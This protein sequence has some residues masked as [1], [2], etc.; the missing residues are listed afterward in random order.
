MKEKPVAPK[1]SVAALS[2]FLRAARITEEMNTSAKTEDEKGSVFPTKLALTVPKKD[3]KESADMLSPMEGGK[4]G[5]RDVLK[6][7]DFESR[8]NELALRLGGM[9]LNTNP[10]PMNGNQEETIRPMEGVLE[11]DFVD[12]AE[13]YLYG[14]FGSSDNV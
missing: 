14:G 1:G 5:G 2:A 13:D 11:D 7:F 6:L 10:R 8:K 12:D 3:W 9:S 4:E